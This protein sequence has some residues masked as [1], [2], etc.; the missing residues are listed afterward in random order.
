V[1]AGYV[2]AQTKLNEKVVL[3]L[4]GNNLIEGTSLRKDNMEGVVLFNLGRLKLCASIQQVLGVERLIGRNLGKY[5]EM[6]NLIVPG[7]GP[8]EIINI[9]EM[10]GEPMR[11]DNF[12]IL[13]SNAGKKKWGLLSIEL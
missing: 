11:I 6:G 12:R 1:E 3:I 10:L 7:H 2:R 4:D 5:D 9:S 13:V 8:T